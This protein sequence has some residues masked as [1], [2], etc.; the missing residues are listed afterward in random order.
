MN[1]CFS[2]TVGLHNSGG[3]RTYDWHVYILIGNFDTRL[4]LSFKGHVNYPVNSDL[5][6]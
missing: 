5:M 4:S 3:V 1:V 6:F 2:L